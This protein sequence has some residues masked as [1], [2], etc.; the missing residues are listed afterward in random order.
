MG[1]KFVQHVTTEMSDLLPALAPDFQ[2]SAFH[3]VY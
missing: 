1:W 2:V 3:E